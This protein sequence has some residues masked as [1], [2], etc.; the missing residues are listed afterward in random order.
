MLD[1]R[2]LFVVLAAGNA[3]LAFALG[4]T[5]VRGMRLRPVTL[6]AFGA[7]AACMGWSVY[8]LRGPIPYDASV[9]AGYAAISGAYAL[10]LAAIFEFAFV[11]I[12]PAVI[13]LFWALGVGGVAVDLVSSFGTGPPII[14]SASLAVALWVLAPAVTLVLVAPRGQRTIYYMCAGFFAVLFMSALY[15]GIDTLVSSHPTLHLFEANVTQSL[16]FFAAFVSMLGTSLCFIILAKERADLHLLRAASVD[17]LTGLLNR[18]AFERTMRIERARSE[19]SRGA[20]GLVLFDLDR[21]KAINDRWGHRAGD[22]VLVR[23]AALL[24]ENVR[25]FDVVARYG[26]EEFCVV[27]HDDAASCRL[28]AERIRSAAAADAVRFKAD[29]IAYTVSAGVAAVSGAG[30]SIE[31]LVDAADQALYEAKRA[32]RNRVA[33]APPRQAAEDLRVP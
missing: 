15:R 9:V 8:A 23:F 17:A 29:D 20:I 12:S 13:A 11:E 5:N 26:G 32:G 16:T 25:P 18:G 2:T 21:F 30:G 10:Q 31:D 28:F 7:V 14:V 4:L 3:I 22:A 1:P 27:V 6:W 24:R 19:R 33:V